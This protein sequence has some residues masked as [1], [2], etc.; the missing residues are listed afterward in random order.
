[1]KKLFSLLLAVIVSATMMADDII[2]TKDSQRI[3]VKIEEVTLDVI[4]YRRS[5]NLNGPLYTLPKSDISSILYENGLVEAFQTKLSR[6]SKSKNGNYDPMATLETYHGMIYQ[7][8]KALTY[9][10]YATLLNKLCPTAYE[11]YTIGKN[12]STTGWAFLGTGVTMMLGIGVSTYCYGALW[13]HKR[14]AVNAGISM[15]VIGGSFIATSVP[16]LCIGY[17]SQKAS[18]ATFNR[19][20]ATAI[21]YNITAGQ[22]GLGLAINF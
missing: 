6:N 17:K 12:L 8:G 19:N 11:Q 15:L 18:I 4:K 16:L 5:D 1:M 9:K 22:N 21:T 14:S 2:V 13:S 10:E 7:N 20:C 3:N